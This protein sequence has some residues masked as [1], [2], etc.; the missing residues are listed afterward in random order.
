ML[1]HLREKESRI[2]VGLMSGTSA[3]GVDASIVR[4]K[5]HSR[6]SKIELIYHYHY[7]YS[8][9]VKELIYR[10]FDLEKA[11][12][13]LLSDMNFLLGEIFANVAIEAIKES[14]LPQGEIDLIA[15]HGQTVFHSPYPKNLGEFKVSSTLQ[16]G[17][18]TVIAERTGITTIC[19]FRVRDISVGGQGAP[20]VP[21]ADWILFTSKEF[22]RG[23]LN[24]GGIANI[25]ILPRDADINDVL[26]F[27]TGPGNMVIDE[28]VRKISNGRLNFDKNGDI[29]RKGIIS[30]K[31]LEEFLSHPYFSLSPPKSTGRE[32][33]GRPFAMNL[34]E[35]GKS[36]GLSDEDIL[37]TT[38]SLTAVTIANSISQFRIE[39]LIIG[40]GGS[41]NSYLI[42]RIKGLLPN[43]RIR[44]HEDFGIPN[45]A[46]EALAFAILANEV[47][48]NSP[49]NVPN[50]TGA[51]KRVILGKVIPGG[52]L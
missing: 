7:E 44:T 51:K 31:L 10:L 26:A 37:A 21:F 41:Y 28:I 33:F 42:E 14:G 30:N 45:Q 22:N 50:A 4:I 39:E 13:P 19:D 46:K 5:G 47:V 29:A 3:D 38:T 12:I 1:E 34:Y 25:T 2:I 24:I 11:N 36:L 27:D 18:G 8:S 6:N 9:E 49:N 40:G 52:R 32:V 16:I 23:V 17:E 15:S 35:R 43:V 48:F 20:L